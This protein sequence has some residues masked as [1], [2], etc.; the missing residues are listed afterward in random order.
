MKSKMEIDSDGIKI[1]RNPQGIY[2]NEDGPA[3][4]YQSGSQYWYIHGDRHRENGPAIIYANGEKCW[5][6]NGEWIE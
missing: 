5:R 6:I 3:V 2:H 1:W 4:I